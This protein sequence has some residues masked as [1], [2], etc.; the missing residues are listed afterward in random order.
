MGSTMS[1]L[2]APAA[3]HSPL[4]AVVAFVIG[5]VIAIC[6][7]P[8][9]AATSKLPKGILAQRVVEKMDRH[10]VDEVE[11]ED[12]DRRFYEGIDHF[13][14]QF[15]R[16][17]SYVRPDQVQQFRGHTE[18]TYIGIG[19]VIEP[20]PE[21]PRISLVVNSGPA[22]AAGVL[23]GDLICKVDGE[24]IQGFEFADV[25]RRIKGRPGTSVH[26]TL[27]RG[28]DFV[29][30]MIPRQTVETSSIAAARLYE[31]RDLSDEKIGYFRL[32]Q[33][34][35]GS[36]EEVFE[37]CRNLIEAGAAALVFDLRANTG[38]VLD[39]AVDIVA[40]FLEAGHIL[41]TRGRK[42][43]DTPNLYKA[44]QAGPFPKQ[45]LAIL[46]DGDSASASEIVAAALR[47]HHR[48]LLIG[49]ESYGKWT[50]QTIYPLGDRENGLLK[51]TTRRHYPPKGFGIRK[52]PNNQERLGLQPDILVEQDQESFAK[53]FGA[54][55]EESTGRINHPYRVETVAKPEPSGD[56]AKKDPV[57]LEALRVLETRTIYQQQIAE[58]RVRWKPAKPAGTTQEPT[59]I[60]RE[61]SKTLE[62]DA[63]EDGK[64]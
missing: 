24:D 16:N 15:D 49:T 18:G 50:V 59:D 39:E 6:C 4:R 37:T 5:G 64:Q 36:S 48:A 45:P 56:D 34:Q 10:F 19:V 27:K 9:S 44:T 61:D 51:L 54:W 43:R 62:K 1:P 28:D 55:Q 31:S 29:E 2:N 58:Q 17:T 46:I 63:P 38:G 14:R 21:Y 13:V 8:Q 30:L 26:M 47:D 11:Q 23:A 7:I 33:F 42:D 35:E 52:D 53:L 32:T 22:A 12:F 40:L 20:L 3:A 41:T 57:L 25:T 60:A